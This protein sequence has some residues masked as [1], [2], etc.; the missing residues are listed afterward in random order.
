MVLVV[1]PL[2]LVQYHHHALA[3]HGR[4]SDHDCLRASATRRTGVR[5]QE[6]WRAAARPLSTTVVLVSR[7]Y[8]LVA[9]SQPGWLHAEQFFY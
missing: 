9:S 4:P 6:E 7:S 5:G 1:L 8:A 2:V 3:R